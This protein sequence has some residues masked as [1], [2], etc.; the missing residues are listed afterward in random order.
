MMSRDRT[1]H[2]GAR[3]GGSWQGGSWQRGSWQRGDRRAP[4]SGR[5]C[6]RLLAAFT[7]TAAALGVAATAATAAGGRT[8]YVSPRGAARSACT[9]SA[10]CRS[11][12]RA[13]ALAGTGGTVRV[14]RGTYRQEVQIAREV[15]VIGVGHPV[16]D[17]TG[18]PNGVLIEGPG[19]AGAVVQ[20]LTVEHATFEGILAERTTGVTIADNVVVDNDRGGLAAHP[21]GECAP[22]GQIPGDCGEGLHLMSV[23][24]SQVI[25]NTVRGN[26][27]GILM[28]DELGPTALNLIARNRSL[29]NVLDCGITLAS[30][31]PHAISATGAPQPAMGGIYEN[32]I[33]GNTVDANGTKGA[34]AGILLAAPAPGMGT[35]DNV[36]AANTADG[37]GQAGITLH[38]HAPGQDLDGNVIVDNTLS[39]DGL[40]G[41]PDFGVTSTVGILVASAVTPLSGI[42]I[43]GN[44][45][46]DTHYGIWTK[47][48]STIAPSANTFNGVTVD[49]TQS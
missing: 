15:S 14:Q 11:I 41:D 29:D 40:T 1:I 19:A 31:N 43:A 6:A 32:L 49:L 26:A 30:H 46:S 4:K 20:G 35:Y 36:V 21:R 38:S 33:T 39:N 27:G 34:G 3:Q 5:T 12:D 42:E 22:Q 23:T 7:A 8:L 9:R 13:I 24:R 10:P 18:R 44:T 28:T 48:V 25:G 2:G 45:I 17:A 16:I 47:G 37:N